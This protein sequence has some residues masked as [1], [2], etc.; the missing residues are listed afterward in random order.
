MLLAGLRGGDVS[1][2]DV[3]I[4]RHH[5]LVLRAIGRL[6]NDADLAEELAQDTFLA[7]YQNVETFRGEASIG[8]WLYRV[9][10]NKARNAVASRIVR[11]SKK[12]RSL[13]EPIE[14]GESEGPTVAE[15]VAGEEADA[16]SKLDVGRQMKA[17]RQAVAALPDIFREVIELRFFD[18]LSYQE[19]AE[20]LEIS[21]GTVKSRI[22]RARQD[23]TDHL[24]LS[25]PTLFQEFFAGE[26][27]DS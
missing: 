25:H 13:D 7:L 10:T 24:K 23:L 17:L 1:C 5:T 4:D 14:P 12:T 9:A 26:A 15:T 8:T 19:I 22:A 20:R 16:R 18:D 27:V 11:Q 3:L 2:L 6:T 21:L